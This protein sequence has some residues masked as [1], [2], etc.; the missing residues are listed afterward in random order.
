MSRGLYG[1]ACLKGEVRVETDGSWLVL[2]GESILTI[3]VSGG[4][5]IWFISSFRM[6]KEVVRCIATLSLSPSSSVGP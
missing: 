4:C 1:L 2:D 5:K 6:G 3:S